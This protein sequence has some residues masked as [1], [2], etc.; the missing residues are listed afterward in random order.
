DNIFI[1]ASLPR[2][3][4]TPRYGDRQSHLHPPCQDSR[5]RQSRIANQQKNAST[6]TKK[7]K[8]RTHVK[9]SN[10]RL[11][12]P[13]QKPVNSVSRPTLPTSRQPA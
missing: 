4:T 9:Q 6:G 12:V 11:N 7:K 3:P 10:N 5:H 13:R 1:F 8:T 2:A